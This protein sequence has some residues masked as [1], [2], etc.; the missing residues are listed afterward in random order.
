MSQRNFGHIS[1]V[2]M[3]ML[4]MCVYVY[5]KRCYLYPTVKWCEWMEQT[6]DIGMENKYL[7]RFFLG[8]FFFTLFESSSDVIRPQCYVSRLK[9]CLIFTL[10][11][12]CVCVHFFASAIRCKSMS[13]N[14]QHHTNSTSLKSCTS[15]HFHLF[16]PGLYVSIKPRSTH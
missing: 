12:V 14:Q 8:Y 2:C 6:S 7:N 16:V 4:C 13:K 3:D 10:S 5:I 1:F 15:R 11:F 9:W